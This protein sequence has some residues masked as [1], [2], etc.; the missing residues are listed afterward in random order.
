MEFSRS[1]THQIRCRAL[2]QEALRSVLRDPDGSRR[3]REAYR[4]VNTVRIASLVEHIRP[5]RRELQWSL[6]VEC[7]AEKRCRGS[8]PSLQDVGQPRQH[9]AAGD[10]LDGDRHGF[11]EL[12]AASDRSPIGR[13][14]GSSTLAF[15]T[16]C[17]SSTLFRLARHPELTNAINRVAMTMFC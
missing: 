14:H 17:Y 5:L 7:D 11:V 6:C 16:C 9:T 8:L 13:Y 10:A 1:S 2:E 3:R 15:G 12:Q 4:P